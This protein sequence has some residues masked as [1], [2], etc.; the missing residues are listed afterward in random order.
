V[1]NIWIAS[2]ATLSFAIE[3]G[4]DTIVS[5]FEGIRKNT[6]FKGRYSIHGAMIWGVLR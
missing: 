1:I 5:L 2:P 4:L 6:I 3:K